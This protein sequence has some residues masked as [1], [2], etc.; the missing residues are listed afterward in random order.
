MLIQTMV[1]IL[2][3]DVLLYQI[4]IDNFELIEQIISADKFY[5]YFGI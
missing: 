4:L 1:R 2:L 3:F 5:I